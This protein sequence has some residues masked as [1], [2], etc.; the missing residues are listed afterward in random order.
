MT[1]K[2][3]QL[4]ALTA[5]C[6]MSATGFAQDI[7]TVLCAGNINSTG[8]PAVLT[9]TGSRDVADNDI[10]LLASSLP[11][12]QFGLY[13]FSL[14][15]GFVA[16]P[17]GS[18]GNLCLG[19][20]IG[21][22]NANV[23]GT[24]A[25]GTAMRVLD[26][27]ALPYPHQPL[28]AQAGDTL[29][30]QFWHR[31][32]SIGAATS[33]LTPGVRIQLQCDAVDFGSRALAREDIGASAFGDFDG[34]GN[35][36]VVTTGSAPLMRIHLGDGEGHFQ[37]AGD[38]NDP[39]LSNAVSVQ[40]V[41]LDGDQDVLVV[42]R[43]ALGE[44]GAVV[45]YRGDGQ[46]GFT[47]DS[48][49]V[50]GPDPQSVAAADFTGDGVPDYA[51]ARPNTSMISVVLSDPS[52]TPVTNLQLSVAGGR[53][54][55]VAE[56]FNGDGSI[57]LAVSG[58]SAATQIFLNLGGGTFFP[59]ASL[60]LGSATGLCAADVD[61]DGDQDLVIA[62][63]LGSPITQTW[64]NGGTGGFAPGPTSG[65]GTTLLCA[66]WNGDLIPDVVQIDALAD[67]IN[68]YAGDGA[69]GFTAGGFLQESDLLALADI[70]DVDRDGF[71]DALANGT[72]GWAIHYGRGPAG[73]A[74]A[75]LAFSNVFLSPAVARGDFDGDG[76]TDIA[77]GFSNRVR[78]GFGDGTRTWPPA[79]QDSIATL[80]AV[81]VL[82][83]G[84]L[85]GDG[86]LD[87]VVGTLFNGNVYVLE[88]T[89]PGFALAATIAIPDDP[90]D[91]DLFDYT[92]NGALDIL[93]AEGPGFGA[94]SARVYENTGSFNFPLLRDW[95]LAFRIFTIAGGDV[96]GDG[97]AD[98][99]FGSFNTKLVFGN[100]PTNII[101]VNPLPSPTDIALL[102][103][104]GNGRDELFSLTAFGLDALVVSEYQPGAGFTVERISG[105]PSGAARLETYDIEGDGTAD[106]VA[107]GG[108]TTAVG[109]FRG[110][111]SG[112]PDAPELFKTGTRT[113]VAIPVDFDDDGIT[114]L[115]TIR[116]SRNLVTITWGT[117][118]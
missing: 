117:C 73:F 61:L 116:T 2:R 76:F 78:I 112:R 70:A 6:A 5:L 25:T 108:L 41:D 26:L 17:A 106:L 58:G 75:P 82:K 104:D 45:L 79:R 52:G 3:T 97:L 74:P 68:I 102:D 8:V 99:A 12:Q 54:L 4:A 89:S 56:D 47:R 59:G 9:A 92:G 36:D 62:R 37:E 71:P 60:G 7:G 114:D 66:D 109:T 110:R 63:D 98:V 107:S 31:D 21:R 51:I 10:T 87:L 80:A 22:D 77:W 33:N 88:N 86:D 115:V 24:G 46:G 90:K 16:N 44:E 55:I 65:G 72:D 64:L 27:G 1:R 38:Y 91:I 118:R 15:A 50:I 14:S 103:M 23:M 43:Q 111:S 29:H 53:S 11:Q 48:T 18:A 32:V 85:D 83:S 20:T 95:Q 42:R 81:E 39:G 49:L 57:D 113:D 28:S 105:S 34:D 94:G 67:E 100:A 13:L 69:G 96:D 19:G 93:V 35:I 40:D 101:E 30:F 84:D